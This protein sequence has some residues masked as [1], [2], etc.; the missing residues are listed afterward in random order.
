M[1]DKVS[2]LAQLALVETSKSFSERWDRVPRAE[3][4]AVYNQKFA[5]QLIKECLE[6]LRLV[7]YSSFDI[8]FGE[9][10]PFQDAV[11]KHFGV[12]Q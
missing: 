10:I 5:D 12:S 11:R 2:E 7:P 8:E 9:E 6:A 4:M 3:F 1:N